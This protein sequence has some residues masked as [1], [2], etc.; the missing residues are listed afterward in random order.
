[1]PLSK[2]ATAGPKHNRN[3]YI[4]NFSEQILYLQKKPVSPNMQFKVTGPLVFQE[5]T[6]QIFTL[7][8][9]L[10]LF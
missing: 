6:E 2:S 10:K 5:K 1:M 4:H 9:S 7:V 8:A 3:P